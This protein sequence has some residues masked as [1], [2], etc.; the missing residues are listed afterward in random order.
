MWHSYSSETAAFASRR[1]LT[2]RA[3]AVGCLIA[4]LAS[5]D[6]A[7]AADHAEDARPRDGAATTSVLGSVQVAYA[8]AAI[9]LAIRKKEMG[10][11]TNASICGLLPPCSGDK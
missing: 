9:A 7:L 5:A 3:M 10:I 1:A 4:T 2:R 8:V 6:A 11:R